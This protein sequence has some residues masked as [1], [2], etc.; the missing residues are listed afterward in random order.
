MSNIVSGTLSWYFVAAILL[1]LP[2][3]WAVLIAHRRGVRRGMQSKAG[4]D[5]GASRGVA[6]RASARESRRAESPAAPARLR[7]RLVTAYGLG[8]LAASAVLTAFTFVTTRDLEPTAFRVFIFVYVLASLA[9]AL[10]ALLND[11]RFG[12]VRLTA[13][14]VLLGAA[15]VLAWSLFSLFALAHANIQPLAN[16]Q[17]YLVILANTAA[18]PF[19][20]VV[21]S[22]ARRTGPVVPLVL[23]GLLVFSSGPSPSRTRSCARSTWRRCARRWRASGTRRC[24]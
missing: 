8:A 9:P 1:A 5:A 24:S 7:R 19:V 20:I 23:A 12:L 6:G 15:V 21:I 16:V 17:A 22:G 18:L 3:S 14:Y 2:A 11:R 13:A 10:A 4:G